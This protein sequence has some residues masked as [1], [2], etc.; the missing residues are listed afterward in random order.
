MGVSSTIGTSIAGWFIME[1]PTKMES[2]QGHPYF[3]KPPIG[4]TVGLPWLLTN[5]G[6]SSLN[7]FGSVQNP[8]NTDPLR[9]MW[10]WFL[11]D[12]W[13]VFIVLPPIY[14]RSLRMVVYGCLDVYGIWVYRFTTLV[15]LPCFFLK[16]YVHHE[17]Y[18]KND[19]HCLVYWTQ[20][21]D[22]YM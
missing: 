20:L 3:R 17:K 12:I 7:Q 16:V 18:R 6:M 19:D 21:I 11:F 8:Q 15:G 5:T 13:H 9:A 1:R 2:N 14:G 4:F 22:V 10:R